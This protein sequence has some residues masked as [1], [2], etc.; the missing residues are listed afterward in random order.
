MPSTVLFVDTAVDGKRRRVKSG[1]IGTYDPEDD[2]DFEHKRRDDVVDSAIVTYDDDDIDMPSGEDDDMSSDSE[3]ITLGK[4]ARR[5]ATKKRLREAN[6]E[7]DNIPPLIEALY[8]N[9]TEMGRAE[10]REAELIGKYGPMTKPKIEAEI[11]KTTKVQEKEE[12]QEFLN[13]KNTIKKLKQTRNDIK[14]TMSKIVEEADDEE[15]DSDEPEENVKA[16]RLYLDTIEDK[17]SEDDTEISRYQILRFQFKTENKDRLK[18]RLEALQD[19]F[20]MYMTLFDVTKEIT[21][22]PF[23]A[24]NAGIVT[25]RNPPFKIG[26]IIARVNGDFYN[27]NVPEK[28]YTVE[29]VRPQLNEGRPFVKDFINLANLMAELREFLWALEQNERGRASDEVLSEFKELEK[30]KISRLLRGDVEATQNKINEMEDNLEAA[31]SEEE[32]SAFQEQIDELKRRNIETLERKLEEEVMTSRQKT[33]IE[34]LLYILK[35]EILIDNAIQEDGGQIRKDAEDAAEQSFNLNFNAARQERLEQFEQEKKIKEDAPEARVAPKQAPVG[36]VT[37][38]DSNSDA[39]QDD[40]DADLFEQDDTEIDFQDVKILNTRE[41]WIHGGPFQNSEVWK[42]V[43]GRKAQTT[44]ELLNPLVI[45]Y[46]GHFDGTAT[47]TDTDGFETVQY[48]SGWGPGRGTIVKVGGKP[49]Y[50]IAAFGNDRRKYPAG[51][52]ILFEDHSMRQREPNPTIE[53]EDW[54]EKNSAIKEWEE[55]VQDGWQA[56]GFKVFLRDAFKDSTE[57]PFSSSGVGREINIT[58]LWTLYGLFLD[59][60]QDIYAVYRPFLLKNPKFKAPIEKLLRM[61][62]PRYIVNYRHTFMPEVNMDGEPNIVPGVNCARV[63]DIHNGVAFVQHL[64]THWSYTMDPFA[65]NSYDYLETWCNK[66]CEDPPRFSELY[67]NENRLRQN[68]RLPLDDPNEPMANQF[69]FKF[70]RAVRMVKAANFSEEKII[71]L[72]RPTVLDKLW[73]HFKVRKPAVNALPYENSKFPTDLGKWGEAEKMRNEMLEEYKQMK[74]KNASFKDAKDLLAKKQRIEEYKE[75]IDTIQSIYLAKLGGSWSYPNNPKLFEEWK[76]KYRINPNSPKSD[77]RKLYNKYSKELKETFSK[78][79]DPRQSIYEVVKD[80]METEMDAIDQGDFSSFKYLGM[81]RN[82]DRIKTDSMLDYRVFLKRIPVLPP[83]DVDLRTFFKT[84]DPG[85]SEQLE[86]LLKIR[87]D[88]ITEVENP[89]LKIQTDSIEKLDTTLKSYSEIDGPYA[90]TLRKAL[91]DADLLR[92]AMYAKIRPLL[93]KKAENVIDQIKSIFE[94]NSVARLESDHY[95]VIDM[96]KARK[97]MAGDDEKEIDKEPLTAAGNTWFDLG[98]LVAKEKRKSLANGSP[99]AYPEWMTP[100]WW[101]LCGP[102]RE[103]PQHFKAMYGEYIRRAAES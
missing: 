86:Q 30:R 43:W 85:E 48:E 6:E 49:A 83:K 56:D 40:S 95:D 9:D 51:T 26:D 5:N 98:R 14:K 82:I 102:R 18:Q 63:I 24:N 46:D 57:M 39:E 71:Q 74:K 45:S 42:W 35:D 78:T 62:Y 99:D 36:I 65:V 34:I 15:I 89:I 17:T 91:I 50:E 2:S 59:P 75:G 103:P 72:A 32:A 22:V 13:I 27:G 100:Q 21:D 58:D 41:G 94:D 1:V 29:Y 54:K 90:Y 73:L 44:Y 96:E 52:E 20:E 19:E 68:D 69:M 16:Y 81:Y 60:K 12:L 92:F 101:A 76:L 47:M 53:F 55:I 84:G 79:S 3:K 7:S 38:D 87:D 28:E 70:Q 37:E 77:Y 4:A 67:I 11:K 10:T 80:K 61:A 88:I 25:I 93:T 8:N 31:E 33:K 66:C 64:P 23:T 97:I